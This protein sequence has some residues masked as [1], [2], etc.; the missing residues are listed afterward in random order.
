MRTRAFIVIAVAALALAGCGNHNLV[1]KVDVLS[2]LSAAQKNIAVGDVPEGSLTEPV[3]IVPDMPIN[4]VDGLNDAAK[5]RSVSL[6]LGGHVA[7][8]SGSGSG[9]FKLYMSGEGVDPL[10]TT[11]VMD[12]PVTFSPGLPGIVAVETA[13][14]LAVAELFTQK[15]L[16]LAMVLDSVVIA[17][18]GVTQ[19]TVTLTKLDAVVI[20]G[21]KNTF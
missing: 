12:V 6:S 20:A 14:S 21:R 7:V 10:T 1:L 9:K 3:P 18:P 15:N 4:L 8:E 13:G 11:P 19:M 2:Y 5:V 16:H 17:S